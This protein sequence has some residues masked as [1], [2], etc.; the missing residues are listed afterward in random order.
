VSLQAGEKVGRYTIARLLAQGGM[1]EVYKAEQDLTGGI[2][3]SVAVKVIRPEY[4]ESPDF[5][6]MFLDEARTAC[7]LSHPNIV[8]IYEVGESAD[9]LL[10]MAMELVPGETLATINRTLRDNEERFSDDALFAIGIATCSALEAVHSLKVEAGTVNLVHRDVSPHNILLSP[11]GA[12]KLIDFGIAKAATNRNLTMPGITKGKAGYFSPEQAMGKLLD[13][14]S[15]LF[16]LGVTL[17]KLASGETPFDEHRGH[18]ERHAALVRGQWKPLASV[19]KG[20]PRSFYAVIDKALALKPEQRFESATHMRE[21]LESAAFEAKIRVSQST[22][23]GFVDGDGEVTAL[24]GSRSASFAAYV[25]LPKVE[26]E[27]PST[28]ENKMAPEAVVSNP[29]SLSQK[30]PTERLLLAVQ[31]KR[32]WKVFASLGVFAVALVAWLGLR[33][34]KAPGP[35]ESAPFKQEAPPAPQTANGLSLGEEPR[36]EIE[37]T[38]V[39]FDEPASTPKF[40][41]VETEAPKRIEKRAPKTFDKPTNPEKQI[42]T[43][44]KEKGEPK[45]AEIPVGE[46]K[47]RIGGIDDLVVSVDGRNWGLTPVNKSIVSGRH[48]VVVT[49]PDGTSQSTLVTVMPDQTS[50]ALLS[51]DTKRWK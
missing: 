48:R 26:E 51:P 22:M 23:K 50:A 45:E 14:R 1:A 19:F 29:G 10:F 35:E 21:A 47:L 43:E 25:P 6:E 44:P 28:D 49:F 42:R 33:S 11:G 27:A 37:P 46:G 34:P 32:R 5:R 24:G 20:L 7:T 41:K 13:G 12:L 39:V 36:I 3:R 17:Y 2:S 31:P 40:A 16:S 15:D 30:K 38:T 18:A 4:S 8:H 9:G